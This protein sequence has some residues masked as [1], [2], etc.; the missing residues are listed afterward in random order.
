MIGPLEAIKMYLAVASDQTSL[1]YLRY[2]LFASI[3]LALAK[4][5]DEVYVTCARECDER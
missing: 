3:C 4:V 5:F 1:D 2:L